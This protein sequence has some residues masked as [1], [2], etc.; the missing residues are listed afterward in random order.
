[1]LTVCRSMRHYCVITNDE[2]GESARMKSGLKKS[3]YFGL[4]AV[5][6]LATAGF[7][8]KADAASYAKVTSNSLLKTDA[9][10]RN[11]APNGTNALYTK[12]GTLKGAKLVATKTTMANLAKSKSSKNYFRAYQVAKTNRGSVYYKIVSFD[13][14]YRGWI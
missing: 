1:M 2:L 3:L 7:A 8:T 6:V 14:K 13:G 12:A 9:T 4:A 5:S 10:T 11:V